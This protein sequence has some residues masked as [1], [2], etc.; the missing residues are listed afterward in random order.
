VFSDLFIAI[1]GKGFYP[2]DVTV[3][4]GATNQIITTIPESIR[5]HK[6]HK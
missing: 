1:R 4:N 6:Y 5:E 2:V 3:I